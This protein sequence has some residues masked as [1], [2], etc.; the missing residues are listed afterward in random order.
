MSDF[1]DAVASTQSF[2]DALNEATLASI[3]QQQELAGKAFLSWLDALG[4]GVQ[5]TT[6]SDLSD[7]L[8]RS[9]ALG[10]D[11]ARESLDGRRQIAETFIASAYVK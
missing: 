2:T 9:V 5:I 4:S 7:S 6:A 8:G 10:F 1:V 3:K 11:L